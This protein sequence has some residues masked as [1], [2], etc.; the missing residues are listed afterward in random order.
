[1]YKVLDKLQGG[2]IYIK[3]NELYSLNKNHKLLLKI[4]L[5]KEYP[6]M[7]FDSKYW[8][9][10]FEFYR[11]RGEYVLFKDKRGEHLRIPSPEIE[12]LKKVF[13]EILPCHM[14]YI[15][16]IPSNFF[17]WLASRK[18]FAPFVVFR[19]ED[20]GW[21]AML[22]DTS[23][24]TVVMK[25]GSYGLIQDKQKKGVWYFPTNELLQLKDLE[26]KTCRVYVTKKEEYALFK[27]NN[28]EGIVSLMRVE[29]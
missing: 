10:G 20:K 26:F 1:M 7:F 28:S 13:N 18:D 23:S 17:D 15:G 5:S 25:S 8:A 2:Y 3:G 16:K 21:K 24:D 29:R 22:Y 11:S 27:S 9:K 14:T 12:N 4:K 6:E 19:N